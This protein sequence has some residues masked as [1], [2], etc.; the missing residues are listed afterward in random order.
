MKQKKISDYIKND[1]REYSLYV[2]EDRA[3]PSIVDGFKP[4]QRKVIYVSDLFIKNKY[5]RVSTLAGRVI[6][7]ASYHHGNAP[8]E[9]C[10]VNMSQDFKNNLPLFDREGQFGKLKSP[11]ASASR[12]LEV[13]L[14][15]NFYKIYKD[16]ELIE[17]K[18][19]EGK[20]IEPHYYLPIIPMVIINAGIAIA[21]GYSSKIL[22]RDYKD[23][24]K[25]C[26]AYLEGKPIKKLIPIIPTFT[27]E[28]TNDKENYKKWFLSGKFVK[29]NAN[30]INIT[31]LP[32]TI[33]FDRIESLLDELYDRKLIA[34]WDNFGKELTDYRIKFF[35]GDLD[36]Y[37]DEKL[38]KL[39]KLVDQVDEVYSVLD[40]HGKLKVF[41][42]TEDILKYFVDFRMKYYD[43]RKQYQLDKIIKDINLMD[44]K[45]KFIKAIIDEKLKINNKKR[46]IIENQII[47]LNIDKIDGN[48][49]YLFNMNIQYLT[50]EKYDELIQN[51]KDK[52]LE[53]KEIEK[54]NPK[55]VYI[56]ELNELLKIKL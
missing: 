1:Y 50:K 38:L 3:I 53:R 49:Q 36:K 5:D 22:N 28:I 42:S 12:Y 32:P 51:I 41:E 8:C 6:S 27:G 23:V 19:E 47:A 16:N 48:Y 14:S 2:L 10:I 37:D 46:E 9:E 55:D 29:L 13:K 17:Y 31:E 35:P 15:S 25:K 26:I 24:I 33:T 52:K 18:N 44:N 7:D 30:T 11:S 39:F 56:S 4:T 21:I 45:A 20:D 43:K 34:N 54:T 40:E